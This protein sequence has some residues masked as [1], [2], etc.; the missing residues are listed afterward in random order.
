MFGENDQEAACCPA[1]LPVSYFT[2][3]LESISQVAGALGLYNLSSGRSHSRRAVA[4][5][6]TEPMMNRRQLISNGATGAGAGVLATLA[7]AIPQAEAATATPIAPVQTAGPF[8]TQ[9]IIAILIGLLLPAVQK[10]RDPY[11]LLLLAGDGSVLV[12]RSL[13][14]MPNS[15]LFTRYVEITSAGDGSV[16]IVDGTSNTIL[17]AGSVPG[18]Q[19]I[20]ILIGAVDQTGRTIGAVSASAQFRVPGQQSGDPHILPFIETSAFAF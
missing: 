9:G 3:V 18:N 11:R 12:Q 10:V 19:I 6:E 2:S 20:A 5:P 16:R 15:K 17:Y 7:T 4:T 1:P 13:P 14:A 8:L